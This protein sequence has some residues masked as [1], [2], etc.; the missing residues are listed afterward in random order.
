MTCYINKNLKYLLNTRSLT[1]ESIANK[2]GLETAALNNYINGS[3]IPDVHSALIMADFFNL[4]VELLLTV[5]IESKENIKDSFDFKFLVLDIDGVMT[6]GGIIYTEAGD[7][8]K[9]FNAKDGLAII[10]LTGAGI[11]VGFL[12]SGFSKKMIEKRAQVLGVQYVYVGTWNKLEILEKWCHEL[13]IGMENV[14]YIGDDTND[15]AIIEKVGLSAC[16]SDATALIKKNVNLIL[17]AGGGKSCVREFV[18]N[19]LS[20]HTKNPF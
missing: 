13:N 15:L 19:Y 6:D 2:T 3:L 11:N 5:D 9:K 12:S 20:A 1:A 7:E 17:I 8:I 10:R 16:P 4:P 14:A 18:D